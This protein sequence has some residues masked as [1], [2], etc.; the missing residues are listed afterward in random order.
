MIDTRGRRALSA[1]TIGEIE[2]QAAEELARRGDPIPWMEQ[3]LRIRTKDRE[4]IPFLLN[5]V[6]LEY[7]RRRTQR[8]MILKARQMGM[9]TVISGLFFADT[10]LH[11]NTTSVMAAHDA[12]S[13][14]MIFRIVMHFWEQLPARVRERAGAPRFANRREFFWPELGSSFYV[15]TAGSSDA[16]RGLTINNLHCSEIAFWREPEESLTSL[17]ETVPIGGRVVWESTPNGAGN[18]FHEEW[19][20]AKDGESNYRSHFYPWWWDPQYRIGGEVLTDLSGDELR[21]MDEH[22]LDDGQ[23]RWR[24]MKQAEPGGR[25]AQEY[26]EDDV[27]CFLVSGRLYFDLLAAEE[28]RQRYT[29]AP[30]EERENGELKIFRAPQPGRVYLLAADVAEGKQRTAQ[31]NLSSEH[32]GADFSHLVIREWERGEEVACFHGRRPE[33]PFAHLCFQLWQEYPGLIIPERN[34]TGVVVA[35]RLHELWPTC[36][37]IDPDDGRPGFRTS[38]ETRN[39]M[40]QLMHEAM[41][42]GDLMAHDEGFWREVRS[43]R[44]Q[45]SGKPA[46]DSGAHDDRVMAWGIS[47]YCRRMAGLKPRLESM[48]RPG[49]PVET[50]QLGPAP[51]A[52]QAWDRGSFVR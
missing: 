2:E 11:P 44:Y 41:R 47:Q 14:E 9:T 17:L 46:A 4:N 48:T 6:Q 23:I 16:G 24:R 52:T 38:A 8:D 29:M 39:Q 19:S 12:D 3:N 30:I 22:G 37:Y 35:N 18:F 36:V 50:A 5:P 40:L 33:I 25:F 10:I 26:P 7:C 28:L 51:V 42:H 34:N 20:R 31:A 21:L 15:K 1:E 43:F 45:D 27:S 32:G 49:R 13:T